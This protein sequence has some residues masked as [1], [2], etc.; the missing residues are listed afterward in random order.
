MARV[1]VGYST[2]SGTARDIAGLIAEELRAAD[3][4]VDVVDLAVAQPLP[5][6]YDLVIVGSGIH[7]GSWYAAATQWLT[8][9]REALANVPVALFNT[10]LNAARDDMTEV[11]LAYNSPVSAIVEPVASTSFAGRFV[12]EKVGFLKR[13]FLRTM[14]QRPKDHVN[15]EA[16][17]SW[18]R[19]LGTYAGS[20]R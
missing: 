4:Q 17:R 13:L 8:Q 20:S 7:A 6:G 5:E 3:R 9:H 19:G 15:P 14:Q 11:C 10:C 12:P 18:V 16:I 2:D 1:L